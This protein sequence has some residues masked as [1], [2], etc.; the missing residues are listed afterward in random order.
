MYAGDSSFARTKITEGLCH[1]GK[2]HEIAR[3]MPFIFSRPV[4]DFGSKATRSHV[5][6]GHRLVAS[7]CR[8]PF[9]LV[10]ISGPMPTPV[11]SALTSNREIGRLEVN[12][13]NGDFILKL[14]N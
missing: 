9:P 7:V 3:R 8:D 1:P 4:W 10:L 14:A 6:R 5:G 11:R 12:P 2:H 13:F